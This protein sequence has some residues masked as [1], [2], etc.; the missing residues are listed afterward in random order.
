MKPYSLT[1][2]RSNRILET[3]FKTHTNSRLCCQFW[4]RALDQSQESLVASPRNQFLRHPNK[5]PTEGLFAF[6]HAD[7]NPHKLMPSRSQVAAL[8][9]NSLP[10][11]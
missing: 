11:A 3:P 6:L 9:A 5:A 7:C 4:Y 1:P 8:D 10:K 2:S